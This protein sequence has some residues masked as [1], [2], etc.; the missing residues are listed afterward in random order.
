MDSSSQTVNV[1]QRVPQARWMV[2]TGKSYRKIWMI[3][4]INLHWDHVGKMW[5]NHAIFTTHDWERFI[6]RIKLVKLGMVY[7]MVYDCLVIL[8]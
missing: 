8:G 4:N 1:Y 2:D 6:P 3:V 7:G 5:K